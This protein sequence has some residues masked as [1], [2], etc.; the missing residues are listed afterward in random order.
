MLLAQDNSQPVQP[1]SSAP[2]VSAGPDT[3]SLVGFRQVPVRLEQPVSSA[4][5]HKGDR[6]RFTLVKNLSVDGRLVAPAGSALYAS[7]SHVRAKNRHRSGKVEFSAAVLD[8]GTGES[9]RF[10]AGDPA[11][12]GSIPVLIL[13]VVILGPVVVALLPIELPYWLF[14]AIRDHRYGGTARAA[15]PVPEDQILAEGQIFMYYA[16]HKTPVLPAT[17]R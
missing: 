1:V 15:K 10:T 13:E 3:I 17:V 4:S 2:I 16:D 6:I 7:V 14:Y 9:V 12:E 8:T 11:D 5:A